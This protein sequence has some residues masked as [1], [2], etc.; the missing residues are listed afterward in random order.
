MNN[1]YLSFFFFLFSFFSFLFFLFFFISF[2]L[3]IFIFFLTILLEEIAKK[4][5]KIGNMELLLHFADTM[6]PFCFMLF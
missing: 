1:V 3:F 5:E 4:L 6:Y 2:Y